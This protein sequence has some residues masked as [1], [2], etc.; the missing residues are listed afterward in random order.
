M[1]LEE[2]KDKTKWDD[3]VT[4]ANGSF[5]QS[6]EWGEFQGLIGREVLR[7]A[8]F[9]GHRLILAIQIIFH[10]LPLRN[11]YL[12][13]PRGPVVGAAEKAGLRVL[14]FLM[15]K[16]KRRG[17]FLRIEPEKIS[18]KALIEN[19]FLELDF[20]IQ[21]KKVLLLDLKSSEKEL[22]A[23]MHSKTRYNI[24]LALKKGV[25]VFHSNGLT[26]ERFEDFWNLVLETSVRDRFKP[27][28]KDYYRALVKILGEF[29][30]LKIFWAEFGNEILAASLLVF[31]DRTVVYLHGAGTLKRRELMASYLLHWQGILAAKKLGFNFYD[32]GGIDEVKW[33]GLSRFKKGFGG[34]VIEYPGAFDYVFDKKRY[35]LYKFLRWLMRR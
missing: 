19:G 22:L 34:S 27:Y 1:R 30:L 10:K 24:N 23:R 2:I 16:I 20:G 15:E 11:F 9:S 35:W 21:P 29:G 31:W 32:F 14:K 8:V 4:Q 3:F 25:R 6:W 13:A 7:L 12:Y 26:P 5:L 18:S 17:F 28:P 33:P